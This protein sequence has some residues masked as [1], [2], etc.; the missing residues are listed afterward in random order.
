M[1]IEN[2]PQRAAYFVKYK[3][4]LSRFQKEKRRLQNNE[5]RKQARMSWSAERLAKQKEYNRNYYL[6]NK[7][8]LN[9]DGK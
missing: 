3:K 4:S 7:T 9:D 1:T 5:Y 6:N 2:K 8:K